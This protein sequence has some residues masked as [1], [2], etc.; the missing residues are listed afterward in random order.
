VKHDGADYIVNVKEGQSTGILN[1]FV[2]HTGSAIDFGFAGLSVTVCKGRV[3]IST[4]IYFI[5]PFSSCLT[6]DGK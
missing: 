3:Q 2:F 5:T 4:R 6:K 1:S